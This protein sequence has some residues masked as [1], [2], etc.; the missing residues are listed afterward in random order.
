MVKTKCGYQSL[1]TMTLLR[2]V[3]VYTMKGLMVLLASGPK[4]FNYMIPQLFVC[5]MLTFEG[6][7]KALQRYNV[8]NTFE[9]S[10]C[11]FE[12]EPMGDEPMVAAPRGEKRL[13]IG[14]PSMD[15]G[16][17]LEKP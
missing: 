11:M 16:W 13:E 2:L 1:V 6:N 17:I 14:L 5:S 3:S 12:E 9:G 8:K 15:M 4:L 7:S 10:T